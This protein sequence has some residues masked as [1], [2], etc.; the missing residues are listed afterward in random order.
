VSR[1]LAVSSGAARSEIDRRRAVFDRYDI[2]SELTAA[3]DKL[4]TH[5]SQQPPARVLPLN[6]AKKARTLAAD[7][8]GQI[9]DNF[10][11]DG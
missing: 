7:F 6:L 8:L 1:L 9:S 5:L 2:V 11:L 10:E 4:H 3:T